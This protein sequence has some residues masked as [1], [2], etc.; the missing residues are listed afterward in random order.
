MKIVFSI[1]RAIPNL[2]WCWNKTLSLPH[3]G[4]LWHISFVLLLQRDCVVKF[5]Y[6]R[7]CH[8]MMDPPP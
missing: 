7:A 8:A 1:S 3:K 5:R 4:V 2:P 6:D